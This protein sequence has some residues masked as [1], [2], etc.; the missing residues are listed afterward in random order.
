MHR[1]K[2]FGHCLCLQQGLFMRSKMILSFIFCLSATT[3]F[4][5]SCLRLT[6]AERFD[7]ATHVLLI[8]VYDVEVIE[9]SSEDSG[10][11]RHGHFNVIERFK[12]DSSITPYIQS[13][14]SPTCCSCDA[15]VEPGQYIIFADDSG[16]AGY[17]HCSGTIAMDGSEHDL[18][19]LLRALGNQANIQSYQGVYHPKTD[20]LTFPSGEQF[21]I[22]NMHVGMSRSKT[23]QVKFL[24]IPIADNRVVMVE[25]LEKEEYIIPHLQ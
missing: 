18:I 2:I 25:F 10:G 17:S 19:T 23:Y 1:Y 14:D 4:A 8:D 21:K 9:P 22:D 24:G 6:P 5:C 13:Q 20:T 16:E 7:Q 15:S 11:I 3:A 12:G